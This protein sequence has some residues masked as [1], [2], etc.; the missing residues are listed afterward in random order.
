[1]KQERNLLHI[2]LI[3]II[4]AFWVIFNHTGDRGFFLFSTYDID[5]VYYWISLFL[6]IASKTAVPLFFM[7][8]GALLLEKD[9]SLKT[10][11]LK[12]I[13]RIAVVLASFS[14]FFYIRK[15]LMGISSQLSLKAFIVELY[16]GNIKVSFWYLYAYIA[17]LISL[18]FLRGLAKNL[19][20]RMFLY[21]L[22]IS[23][24]YETILPCIEFILWEGEVS[25][26]TS[27]RLTW[28]LCNI[29]LYPI[30]GYYLEYRFDI[31]KIKKQH[32]AAMW[33]LSVTGVLISCFMTCYKQ[34][35]TGVLPESLSQEFHNIFMLY[36]CIS[37]YITI[38]YLCMKIKANRSISRL[39]ISA[40]SCTFGIYLIHTVILESRLVSAL[41]YILADGIHINRILLPLIICFVVLLI[42]YMI[43]FILKKFPVIKSFI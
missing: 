13:F 32:V 30:T 33:F 31:S 17:L 40:G 15:Y 35:I 7:I 22:G 12:K 18:P 14:L 8:T 28:L 38:K 9:Y 36:L 26:N 6:S 11:W 43:T 39:I 20:D 5:T 37:V 10:I 42:G 2:E 23:F 4:A 24:L 25:V 29:V 34:M 19:T 41:W 1:M 21:L 3:R 16:E 27:V